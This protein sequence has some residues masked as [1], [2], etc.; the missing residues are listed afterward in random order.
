M[1]LIN[2]VVEDVD[3]LTDLLSVVRIDLVTSFLQVVQPPGFWGDSS[4]P[5]LFLTFDDGPSPHTTPALLEILAETD[6]KATFF[7]IGKEAEKF[8]DLVK[9]IHQAGHAIGNHSHTHEYLP[10]L[11]SS[12][13]EYQ[14][15]KANQVLGDIIGERVELFRPPFGMMDGRVASCLK[16]HNLSA[17]YWTSAP[18]DWAIP[19]AARVIRRVQWKLKRGG[20]IVLHEGKE[21]AKQTLEA[22]KQIIYSCRHQH[23]EL[24]KVELCLTSNRRRIMDS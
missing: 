24:D 20:I 9:E 5:H 12:E 7:L 4:L 13:I 14:V 16:K 17:V 2:K 22:A 8:P 6:T 11:S 23:L 18:E 10:R 21:L 3:A 15:V 19:G 1:K